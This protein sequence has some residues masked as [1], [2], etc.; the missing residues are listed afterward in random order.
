M[1]D[2]HAGIEIFA[3]RIGRGCIAFLHCILAP[4]LVIR[5][6]SLYQAL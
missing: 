1:Q 4:G 2:V 3:A 6:F 5:P